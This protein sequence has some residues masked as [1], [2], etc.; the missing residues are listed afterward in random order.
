MRVDGDAAGALW[1]DNQ[2][3]LWSFLHRFAGPQPPEW[4]VDAARFGFAKA[5][6]AYD[7][8][9]GAFATL[10]WRVMRNEVGM[11]HRRRQRDALPA[12]VSLEG[13]M[14]GTDGLTLAGALA[15]DRADRDL[16][17]ALMAQTLAGTRVLGPYVLA[18]LTH[19]EIGRRL[20]YSQT[21]VWKIYRR[22]ALAWALAS[23]HA[24][25]SRG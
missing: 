2:R 22:E 4:V 15:D 1:R 19:R 13:D 20:G 7:P 10:A 16:D 9:R 6:M 14:A 25:R 3:V 24:L 11:E 23:G 18:G 17:D 5:C 21:Y 8:D 12:A